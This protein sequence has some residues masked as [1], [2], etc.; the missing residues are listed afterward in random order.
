M[1]KY[2]SA[3]AMFTTSTGSTPA[4]LYVDGRGVA[5]DVNLLASA[6]VPD[7]A[8][9]LGLVLASTILL[10]LAFLLRTALSLRALRVDTASLLLALLTGAIGCER[11]SSFAFLSAPAAR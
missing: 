5:G 6:V 11:G 10:S 1:K 4:R 7:V 8:N 2:K 9:A 3:G